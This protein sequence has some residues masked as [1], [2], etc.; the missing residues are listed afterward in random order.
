MRRFPSFLRRSSVQLSTVSRN[1]NTASLPPVSKADVVFRAVTLEEAKKVC[2]F[3]KREMIRTFGHLYT[4]DDFEAY[5]SDAYRAET[6][7]EWINSKEHFVYG[8]YLDALKADLLGDVVPSDKE[9]DEMVAYVLAGPCDLPLPA[10][11]LKAGVAAPGG[12]IKR[13][14]AHPRTFGSGISDEL[15][16]NALTWLR[17]GEGMQNRDIYLGVYSENPR[18]IKFYEKHNFQICG[19]YQFPVGK[20]LDRELIMK[21]KA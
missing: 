12:E 2:N 14:Y 6:Y 8:A 9:D 11:E 7:E 16:R 10:Q 19:E 15:I 13:M 4:N 21:N 20:Q 1:M 18:A 17:S 5:L 3:G